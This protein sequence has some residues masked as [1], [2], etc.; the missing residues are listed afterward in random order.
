VD[1]DAA[2]FRESDRLFDLPALEV[3]NLERHLRASGQIGR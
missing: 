2:P 1:G 3:A